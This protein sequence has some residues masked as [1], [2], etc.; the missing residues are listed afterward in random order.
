[1]TQDAGRTTGRRARCS[2]DPKDLESLLDHLRYAP[3]SRCRVT[4]GAVFDAVGQRAF[5]P[6]LLVCGLLLLTP[7]S[8]IPGMATAMGLIAVLVSA[9]LLM[10]RRSFWLPQWL[11]RRSARGETF[12]RAIDRLRRPARW[13]DK[14]LRPRLTPLLRTPAIQIIAVLC[15]L[16][17]LIMPALEFIPFSDTVPALGMAAFGLALI[18]HDGLLAALAAVF[19]IASFGLVFYAVTL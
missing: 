15:L 1:M 18:A 14:F 2:E 4:L 13:V 3:E 9:Q 6:I 8:G 16:V 19:W 7:I 11:M 12:C 10:G 17:G 5:G